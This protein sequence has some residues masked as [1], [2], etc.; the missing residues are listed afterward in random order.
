MLVFAAF[1]A[2]DAPDAPP[3]HDQNHTP[4]AVTVEMVVFVVDGLGLPSNLSSSSNCSAGEVAV[5]TE[6]EVFAGHCSIAVEVVGKRQVMRYNLCSEVG[7]GWVAADTVLLPELEVH[8]AEVD[9]D[10]L[11][12]SIVEEQ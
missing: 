2:P 9:L 8:T 11:G 10:N 1:V 4:T 5:G 6:V 7:R 3:V 12:Q